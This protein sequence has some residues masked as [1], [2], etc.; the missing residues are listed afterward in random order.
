[1]TVTILYGMVGLLILGALFPPWE[2][3]P[4]QPPEFLG[5][6][7]VGGSPGTAVIS[8][9][10]LTIVGHDCRSGVLLLVALSQKA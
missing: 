1:M 5:F 7:V 6:H 4:G 3:P 2:S 9:L 10:L 8:R